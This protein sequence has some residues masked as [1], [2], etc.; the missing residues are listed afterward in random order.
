MTQPRKRVAILGA[1]GRDFHNFNML[2]RDDAS[3]EVVAFTATQI[4]GI[5]GRRYPPA[6]AGPRYPNGIPIVDAAGLEDLIRRERIAEV[7]FAYSDVTH[8]EVMHQASRALA[9]GADFALAGPAR[10]MIAADKPVIA[11]SAVRTGC[12]KSQTA[13]HLARHLRGRGLGVAVLRH[14]M[15]YGDLARQAVQRFASR[16]DLDAANCTIEEREEYEPHIDA[17]GVVF[18][19]VDYRA[20]AAAAAREAD[21]VLWDGGNNDFPFLRP[22]LHVVVADA[23]RP[24]QL[25]THHPGETVLRMADVVVVNK[26]DAA[27]PEA[28]RRI[29]HGIR[30]VVRATV[31]LAA[32]PAALENPDAVRGR[33]VVVVEDGPTIT[34]GGMPHGAGV[35]ALA[36][37]RGVTL[38]DPRD[39]APP[40]L[41]QVFDAYPHI[42]RVL[43][44]MGYSP[45]QRAALKETIERSAAEIVVSATPIDLAALLGPGKPVVRVRYDY[46]DAGEP[47]LA[48]L[49]DAF[50]ARRSR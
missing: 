13:R 20:I 49:V 32:S 50:L 3:A 5:A 10:T 23:L 30:A 16:A 35:A 39:S 1:A 48:D 8:A 4:P 9:A 27:A 44:A 37:I 45:A 26:T 14:P 24:D 29:V 38:V 43:P 46:A 40:A 41:R 6:L 12:G 31:V 2:Y 33:R 42:G 11:I 19:G 25:T 22:D 18:A 28:V 34:H 47:R 17:G 7:M 15:P 21:I 36:G